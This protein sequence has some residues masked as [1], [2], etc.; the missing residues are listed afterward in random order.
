MSYEQ[1]FLW[2]NKYV[3]NYLKDE[4]HIVFYGWKGEHQD[5]CGERVHKIS[6]ENAGTAIEEIRMYLGNTWREYRWI[7][8]SKQMFS[9][10]EDIDAIKNQFIVFKQ[11][12]IPNE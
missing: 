2:I 3:V 4:K 7:G 8:F 1:L 12:L 9:K 5:F 6:L 11:V 10:E